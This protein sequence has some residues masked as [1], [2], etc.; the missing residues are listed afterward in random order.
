MAVHCPGKCPGVLPTRNCHALDDNTAS[1]SMESYP[2]GLL[3]CGGD[4]RTLLKCSG[5]TL[6]KTGTQCSMEKTCRSNTVPGKPTEGYIHDVD[7]TPPVPDWHVSTAGDPPVM[8]CDGSIK[9]PKGFD[10]PFAWGCPKLGDA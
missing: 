1:F 9:P 5:G 2:E 10:E 4:Q 8:K 3:L 7:S 6:Q